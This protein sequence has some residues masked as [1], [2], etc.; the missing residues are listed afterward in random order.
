MKKAEGKAEAKSTQSPETRQTVS[1]LRF[2]DP[3]QGRE[4]LC[5][6][7]EAVL[8]SELKYLEIQNF[9]ALPQTWKF[10]H[11]SDA[12]QSLRK[13]RGVDIGILN[14]KDTY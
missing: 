2:E 11:A 13:P 4:E 1:A 9:S 14:T 5:E 3:A 6:L 8:F 12:A 10:L 7:E